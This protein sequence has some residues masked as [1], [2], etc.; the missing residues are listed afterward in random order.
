MRLDTMKPVLHPVHLVGAGPGDPELLTL[1]AVRVLR[2]ATVI[3]VDDLVGRQVLGS[4]LEGA[5]PAPRVIHVGKRGGCASTPQDF[6]EKLMVREALAGEKVVR[7]KGGDPLIF[8]RAGEEIA[9]LRAAGLE[10]E[11]VNGI[12]A[13]LGAAA[14]LGVGWTDRRMESQATLLLTGHARP[15]SAGPDWRGIAALAATGVT[16]VIYMGV[17]RLE[18]IAAQLLAALPADLPAA[19]VERASTR[20]ERRLV[21]T[22]GGLVDAVAAHGLGSPAV[23]IIGRVLRDARVDAFGSVERVGT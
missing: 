13:G 5:E 9:A 11:I 7:L 18:Q 21:T 4:V 1:K 23:L 3:L 14:S 15:G 20:D 19:V 22:L 17:S 10:V 16:L 12:T 8:G 2:A 6:I